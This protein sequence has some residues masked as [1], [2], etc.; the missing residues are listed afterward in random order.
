MHFRHED[1]E[2]PGFPETYQTTR[3]QIPEDGKICTVTIFGLFGATA[4]QWARASPFTRFLGHTNDALHSVE[5]LWTSD[6]LVA[7]TST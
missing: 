6:Q 1:G 4:P 7:E 5:L 2:A 3:C